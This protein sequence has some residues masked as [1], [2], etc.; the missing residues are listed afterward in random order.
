[1]AE[2]DMLEREVIDH[3]KSRYDARVGERAD[4]SIYRLMLEHKYQATVRDP[5]LKV[6]WDRVF[7][8]KAC[9]ACDDALSHEAESYVCKKC[10]FGIPKTLFD[11]GSK[12]H[13]QDSALAAQEE[14]LMEKAKAA[15]L[16]DHRLKL[17]YD[18]A[19]EEAR[20]ERERKDRERMRSEGDKKA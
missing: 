19:V 17:L 16:T 5:Y 15:G 12:E 1:M 20:Q 4:E 9:P 6:D 8:E 2:Y 7:K 18:A 10:G 13:E 11:A 3:F 14:A